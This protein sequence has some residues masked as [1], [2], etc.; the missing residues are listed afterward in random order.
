MEIGIHGTH[1]V[2]APGFQVVQ[3]IM[4]RLQLDN[5]GYVEFLTD[6]FQ[7]VNV[8]TDGFA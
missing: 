6:E 5:V 2:G 3:R 4:R 1:E 8:V 7:Q